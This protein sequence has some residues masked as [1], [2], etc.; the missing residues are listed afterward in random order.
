MPSLDRISFD[1]VWG[2]V[3]KRGERRENMELFVDK[4]PQPDHGSR[5]WKP[6]RTLWELNEE[7][8]I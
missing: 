5:I 2:R 4:R 1:G 7:V 3:K 6:T 8:K